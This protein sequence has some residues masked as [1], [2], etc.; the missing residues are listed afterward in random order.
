MNSG[1]TSESI[2]KDKQ[3][4]IAT[5][6]DVRLLTDEP[7]KMAIECFDVNEKGLI[8]IGFDRNNPFGRSTIAVYSDKGDFQY[9]YQFRTEG[10]Y[11]FEWAG[12]NVIIHIVRSDWAVLVNPN[13]EVEEIREVPPTPENGRFRRKVLEATKKQINNETYYLKNNMGILNLVATNYSQLWHKTPDNN[14]V[15]LYDV[16]D[17]QLMKK[18]VWSIGICLFAGLILHTVGKEFVKLRKNTESC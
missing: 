8:A 11:V 12:E 1:Y 2:P 9:G 13:G 4:E 15:L 6:I 7:K 16:N 10:T 3:E 17:A 14:E 5:L 18:I